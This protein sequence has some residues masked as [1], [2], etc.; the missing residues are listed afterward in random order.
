MTQPSYNI[1]NESERLSK[2]ARSESRL[3]PFIQEI[4]EI[5]Y[6]DDR[7]LIFRTGGQLYEEYPDHALKFVL[8]RDDLPLREDRGLASKVEYGIKLQYMLTHLEN[9]QKVRGV[10]TAYS[11]RFLQ[12]IEGLMCFKY[13]E[14]QKMSD[15]DASSVVTNQALY[16]MLK[17]DETIQAMREQ[18]IIHGDVKPDNIILREAARPALIDFSS[19]YR[20]DDLIVLDLGTPPY[21]IKENKFDRDSGALAMSIANVLVP[22]LRKDFFKNI[23]TSNRGGRMPLDYYE[24]FL[25]TYLPVISENYGDLAEAYLF[26]MFTRDF[27]G[28]VSDDTRALMEQVRRTIGDEDIAYALQDH[29]RPLEECST[30]HMAS[31]WFMGGNTD[32]LDPLDQPVKDN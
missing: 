4:Q 15:V 10:Q 31:T 3:Q 29:T 6:I 14:G 13:V 11:P 16:W 2:F 25:D 27:S 30:T 18:G 1:R 20:E 32:I 7:R 17:L 12:G 26:E 9:G 8:T 5:F 28:I 23:H 22:E 19:A 24:R 21:V